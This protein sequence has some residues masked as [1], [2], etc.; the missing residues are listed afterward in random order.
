MY[1]FLSGFEEKSDGDFVSSSHPAD[2][3]PHL[4]A[5]ANAEHNSLRIKE[6]D[7]WYRLY[8]EKRE[9][10]LLIKSCSA[11][12]PT[13]ILK[14]W[15]HIFPFTKSYTFPFFFKKNMFSSKVLDRS[16]ESD[17]LKLPIS[18]L[19]CLYYI[20]PWCNFWFIPNYCWSH[21]LSPRALWP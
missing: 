14:V 16:M 5:S 12:V 2:A 20:I 19:K 10:P 9:N 18:A 17:T 4:L 7:S 13:S 15:K 6:L 8:A 1:D 3:V 21:D 11:F